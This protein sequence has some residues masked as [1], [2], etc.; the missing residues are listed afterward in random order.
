MN[1]CSL[2]IVLCTFGS[3]GVGCVAGLDYRFPSFLEGPF[4]GL[5]IGVC[6]SFGIVWVERVSFRM[7]SAKPIL[8]QTAAF[9]IMVVM[10]FASWGCTSVIAQK[11][12][13]AFGSPSAGSA[14]HP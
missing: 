13:A 14:S 5:L 9:L 4:L 7:V 1:L 10:P 12:L 3:I 8:P 6:F 11:T 2:C